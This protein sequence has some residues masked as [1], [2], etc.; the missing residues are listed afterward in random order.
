MR[1]RRISSLML[2]TM[3]AALVISACGK[4]VAPGPGAESLTEA[5]GVVS[6]DSVSDTSA[7]GVIDE[8]AG[9]GGGGTPWI[10]SDIKSN[11]N[12]DTPVDPA[13]DFHLYA[14]KEW[15][16]ENSIPEGYSSWSHY[17]ER[18][19][20]VKKQC[21]DLLKDESIEGHDAELIRTY[22]SLVLDW[23]ARNE[24]GIS[25]LVDGY[26]RL[27]SLSSLDDVTEVLKDKD[28]VNY[29]YSFIDYGADTG[30]NDPTTFIV[31]VSSSSLIL[32]DSAEYL[33]RTE[34]GDIYYGYYG[35]VFVYMAQRYGMT[36][37][38]ARECFDRAIAL[39]TR[40]APDIYTTNDMYSD[41]FY[42][43]INNEMS[44]DE[45]TALCK[46]FPLADIIKA[47][48][49]KYDG[50]YL[51]MNPDYLSGLDEIYTEDNFE[52]I[53]SLLIVKYVLSNV[54]NTDREAYEKSNEL[55]NEY[56]GKE[57][58]L[59][60]EEMAYNRVVSQLPDSMQ[61]VYIE[62]YGSEEDRQK[63][64]EL[65]QEVIDTYSEMLAEND[66][67]SDEVKDYAIEKLNKI[68]IHA[69]YPDK[70]KDTSGIDL[71]DCS[72][73]EAEKNINENNIMRNIELIGTKLDPEKWAEFMSVTECNA[74]YNPSDNSINM[75]IGM[76]GEPFYSSDMSVEELYA[77]I[78]AFWVGHEISHAFDNSGAQFDAEGQYRDWWTE[79]DKEEF[80]KRV[81]RMDDYLDTIVAFDDNHFIGTNI[82]TEMIA[83][84]T[85]L[86]CALRMASKVEG[87]DY[88]KFFIKY[89]QMNASIDVY[90]SELS[91][92]TQDAHPLN[93]S[94]TNVPVQQFE[95]FYE[96]FDVKEGD[97]MYLAPEDRLI[98]W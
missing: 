65:C 54:S 17:T 51:V 53:R 50:I 10:D 16:L 55:A 77:S 63:M 48:G 44:F 69:A 70:F 37:N 13:D 25:E 24:A 88:Q 5:T 73:L 49:Y 64:T 7:E 67:A 27:A 96:A 90:S 83:D 9:K 68:T 26:E 78:G 22:N 93:Y 80:N 87:F 4:N 89:A 36:E 2:C 66:W 32:S 12:S 20:E 75:I 82:D 39:E 74:F 19:L 61:I 97:N 6:G 14:N 23:D 46:V 3:S 40:L 34:L 58:M 47:S 1:K 21:I 35:D 60:D 38:E 94:R 85:G 29:T 79:A 62:K 72:L 95:E 42:D 30:L 92:L 98:V 57:G 33:E 81:G 52:D 43:R 28:A 31:L 71:T 15:I 18:G 76:M 11:I 86:Q 8:D 41:D 59:S 56:F 84:M 45:M 91:Q